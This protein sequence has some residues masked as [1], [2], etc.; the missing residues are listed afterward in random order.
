MNL[1]LSEVTFNKIMENIRMVFSPHSGASDTAEFRDLATN[2]LGYNNILYIATVFSELELLK[3]NNGYTAILIEEPEAHLHP[4]MQIKFIKYIQSVSEKDSGAQIIITTHSPILASSVELGRLI[5]LKDDNG[6]ISAAA[7]STKSFG[8]DLLAASYLNR[9]LDATKSAMLFSRGVIL[10]EGISE[11]LVLPRLAQIVLK[12]YNSSLGA[13]ARRLGDSLEDMGVSVININGTNFKPFM[14]LFGNF[15]GASGDCIPIRCAGVTD[16]DP[17]D[18]G[19]PSAG[20]SAESGNP[21][22]GYAEE[23]NSLQYTR[24]FVSPQKT[25]EYDLALCNPVAMAKALKEAWGNSHGGVAGKLDEIIERHGQ[26]IS[27]ES[28]GA[29]AKYIYDHIVNLP[30][31]KGGFASVLAECIGND[32]NVPEYIENAV[33]WACGADVQ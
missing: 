11:A 4:Q 29:D 19:Y 20:E 25:F 18:G 21:M 33:L 6:A 1:Q 9:W 27:K 3:N 10:V 23:I 22:R 5:H 28:L 12:K 8:N 30:S 32:F 17:K 7:M 31:G 24:L 15:D 2:S 14:K 13:G 16:N 26:E